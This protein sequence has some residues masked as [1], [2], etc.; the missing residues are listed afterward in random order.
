MRRVECHF[1]HAARRADRS[2]G[3]RGSGV[4]P[5][6]STW[7]VTPPAGGSQPKVTVL[8]PTVAV[9]FD[10]GDGSV[11]AC[12]TRTTT[13]VDGGDVPLVLLAVTLT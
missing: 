3:E 8:P 7:P 9:R 12:G 4:S 13:F 1:R 2:S 11:G 10:G 6:T 5:A